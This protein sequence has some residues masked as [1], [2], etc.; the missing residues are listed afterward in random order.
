MTSDPPQHHRAS[1]IRRIL[2]PL[3]NSDLIEVLGLVW[4]LGKRVIA[5]QAH[6]GMYEVLEYESQL[7][8][9]DVRGERAVL[10]KRQVVNFLQ[11]R[12]LAYQDKAW[13]DGQI[14]ADY[15][16]APGAAVDRYREGHRWYI[17]I[18]LRKTMNRGD[19]EQ[20][21]IERTIEGGFTRRVEDFQTEID[22]TTRRLAISIVF[23]QQRPPRQ[24]MLIEQNTT[25]TVTLN[26]Q[27][28]QVLPDGRHQVRWSTDNPRLFEAYILRWQ[29]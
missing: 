28:R 25:R 26:A 4:C 19:R 10:T 9:Q 12:I 20:F 2:I 16:C 23:P 24:V 5:R 17:L 21:H 13:G 22:H 8:L 18:S 6:E 14:F 27:Q 7:E 11:D 3:L 1:T 15:K 29:W